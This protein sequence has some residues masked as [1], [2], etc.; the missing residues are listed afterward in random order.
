MSKPLES[1]IEKP[2]VELAESHGWFVRKSNWLQVKG[3]PDR[4]FAKDKRI[5]FIEFKR[6]GDKARAQQVREINKMKSA[7]IEVHVIDNIETA[8]KV[9]G[10]EYGQADMGG[11][12]R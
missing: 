4:F 1:Q 6:P 8:L 2:V 10:I 7:G 3:C 12:I 11:D 5:V 9:L